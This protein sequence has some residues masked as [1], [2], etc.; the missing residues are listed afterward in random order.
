MRS[1]AVICELVLEFAIGSWKY[2]QPWELISLAICCIM[3]FVSFASNPK[4]LNMKRATRLTSDVP[5]L[6]SVVVFNTC[7]LTVRSS[8]CSNLSNLCNASSI[9]FLPISFL[10]KVPARI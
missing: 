5:F 7:A 3:S 10:K 6:R 2:E 9:S 8:P 1:P 4:R